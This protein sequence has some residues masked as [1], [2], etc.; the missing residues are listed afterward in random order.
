MVLRTARIASIVFL[1]ALV[2]SSVIVYPSLPDRIPSHF[3]F[4]GRPTG[5]SRTSPSS[6]F[7]L[8]IVGVVVYLIHAACSW[9]IRSKP[10][11]MNIPDRRRFDALP[12]E[13]KAEIVDVTIAFLYVVNASVQLI[14]LTLMWGMLDTS[15]GAPRMPL[16]AMIIQYFVLLSAVFSGPVFLWYVM[17]RVRELHR[18]HVS[19]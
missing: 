7:L 8:P 5:W 4:A 1:I 18:K 14:F 11:L 2:A 16:L 10:H 3:D 13:A 17:S 19:T 9:F 12:P 6:W 15:L